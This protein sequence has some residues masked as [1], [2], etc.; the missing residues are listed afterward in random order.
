MT[1]R[2]DPLAALDDQQRA[3]ASALHGPVVIYAG[4]G[5]GKTRTITHRIA[6]GV[7][8]G[9]FDPKATLAV[10]F[11]SRAAGELRSRLAALGVSGVQVRTFHGAALRQLRYFYPQVFK[12]EFPHLIASKTEAL[13]AAAS[14]CG[15]STSREYIRDMA[16][17][18]EWAKANVM[19]PDVYRESGRASNAGEVARLYQTYLGILDERNLID[20]EDVLLLSLAM[21][22][23]FPDV[24]MQVHKQYRHFTVDE[25]Q[26]VSP[27]QFE[28]LRS[29]LGVGSDVCVVG[30]PAQT[31]YSFT[32]ASDKFLTGFAS[33]FRDAAEFS[34]DYSYRS[35]PEIVAVANQ[36]L[37]AARTGSPLKAIKDSGDPVSTVAFPSDEAEAES[38]ASQAASLI[39]GG[40]RPSE[41]AVLFRTNSQSEALE[42]A[43]HNAG[44]PFALRGADR[45]FERAEVRTAIQAIRTA[46]LIETD[47][48]I[49]QVVRDSLRA[50]GWSPAAPTGGPA[51]RAT[52]ESLRVLVDLAQDFEAHHEDASLPDFVAWLVLRMEHEEEPAANAVTLATM[53]A[54]KGLEWDCVFVVGLSDGFMPLIHAKTP[55]ALVEERRLLYVA[56]TRAKKHLHLSWARSRTAG[57][58]ATRTA[59]PFLPGDS[60]S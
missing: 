29:W 14:S 51:A 12:K 36:V 41:I 38:V 39:A 11:T 27:V 13:M 5:S 22:T 49:S 24:A 56:M 21:L 25:F 54:A 55:A 10:T 1:T 31:I 47:L 8:T 60:A 23:Q 46:S 28:L 3:A 32:G 52:W 17:E 26:D 58:G 35:T 16:S 7:A 43:F 48:A 50:G 19:S 40:T 53:H 57:S 4:A 6:H 33:S 44:I 42:S 9:A 15:L 34:L 37:G 30:D 45:F 2:P 20:F 59:S 18:I